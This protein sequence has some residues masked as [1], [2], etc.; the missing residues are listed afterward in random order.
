M[1]NAALE[2]FCKGDVD[3]KR[4]GEREDMRAARNMAEAN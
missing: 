2:G 3:E 1:P 4:K